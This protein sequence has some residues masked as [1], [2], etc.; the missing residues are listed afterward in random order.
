M[1]VVLAI[2][3]LSDCSNTDVQCPKIQIRQH[4]IDFTSRLE[5]GGL[6]VKKRMKRSWLQ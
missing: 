4:Q 3:G 2:N 5:A 1:I 6:S